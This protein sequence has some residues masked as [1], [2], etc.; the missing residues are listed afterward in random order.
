MTDVV[1]PMM[2]SS[3][4]DADDRRAT[5]HAD[6]TERVLADD[7]DAME[8]DPAENHVDDTLTSTPDPGPALDDM[9]ADSQSSRQPEREPVTEAQDTRLEQGVPTPAGGQWAG[10][11]RRNPKKRKPGEDACGSR[12]GGV[13]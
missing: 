8:D 13:M 5:P 9:E 10:R 1:P 6:E 12:G 11:L 3:P 4:S 2:S 7:Q